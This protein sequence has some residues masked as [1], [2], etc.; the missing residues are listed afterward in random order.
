MGGVGPIPKY[1]AKTCE[2]LTNKSITVSVIK[3]AEALLQTELSPISD[4]RGTEVY[5]RLLGRQLFF[6]H[7]MALFPQTIKMEDLI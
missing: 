3:E 2:F 1:L 7:F 6:A 4:A 5:K